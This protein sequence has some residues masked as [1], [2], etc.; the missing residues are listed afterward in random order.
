MVAQSPFAQASSPPEFCEGGL[1]NLFVF[2]C[3]FFRIFFCGKIDGKIDGKILSSF[4]EVQIF[5]FSRRGEHCGVLPRLRPLKK[6]FFTTPSKKGTKF[7]H[8]FP[9]ILPQEKNPKI[10]APPRIAKKN[11]KIFKPALAKLGRAGCLCKGNL[12]DHFTPPV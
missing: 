5:F 1:K 12:C 8:N 4:L 6:K 7:S 11:E 10:G 3:D 9:T 2:F